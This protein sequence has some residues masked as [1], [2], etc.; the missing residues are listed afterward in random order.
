MKLKATI[1]SLLSVLLI[2]AVGIG[3]Y[4]AMPAIVGTIDGSRYYTAEELQQSYDK[5]YADGAKSETEL[6][7][8][9][10]YY[11]NLVDE[12][13]LNVNT[14][15]QEITTLT[16]SNEILKNLARDNEQTINNLQTVIN[17]NDDKIAS[18]NTEITALKK[19]IAY[20][21]QLVANLEIDG[22]A[23]VTFEFDGKVCNFQVIDKN[24]TVMV[25]D[26][27]STDY[28]IFNGWTVDGQPVDLTTYQ[29]TGNTRFVADVTYRYQISFVADNTKIDSYLITQGQP[30]A[31]P[32]LP[33]KDGYA[34]DGWSLDGVNPIDLAA[35][36][37][38][39]NTVLIAVFTKLH[40]V[41]FVQ[42]DVIIAT[43][44]VRHNDCVV[45]PEIETGNNKIFNGWKLSD[46]II[47]L[48]NYHV[49]N[50]L[51]L[52]AEI[53]SA[54]SY[55]EQVTIAG[56]DKINS[57]S[58]IWTD[59]QNTYY[60][61]FD[62]QL[63][64]NKATMTWEPKTWH[65][66]T[67]QSGYYVWTDGNNT[68]YTGSTS[69]SYVLNSQ[70]STW[71]QIKFGGSYF[72]VSAATNIWYDGD[73]IYYSQNQYHQVVFNKETL[74]WDDM[75]WNGDSDFWASSVWTDGE[76]CYRGLN[77]VLDRATN[78]W[79][80]KTWY[81][82]DGVASLN[83]WTDGNEVYG[84]RTVSGTDTHYILDKNTDTWHIKEWD[85]FAPHYTNSFWTD[86][87]SY[88]Y[89]TVGTDYKL[90]P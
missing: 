4:C 6:L 41:T 47:D 31:V 1:I 8:Q 19:S 68:Y 20:Y 57:P 61:S 32:T 82:L 27:V 78:T 49:T 26:P 85:G 62:T 45:A 90:I 23:V 81:G 43:E 16:K 88:Y 12:Y 13:Y 28:V 2:A 76:N 5:G 84:I 63:V 35:H 54:G 56:A 29:V 64:L 59:G 48:T 22:Q 75:K 55:F 80:E 25:N 60:S 39:E 46:E 72:T 17:A 7:G 18:L 66:Y 89:N 71:S 34:F 9:V 65:G 21:E 37:V 3:I 38:T 10:Q 87:E 69:V 15:N 42:S 58:S 86:G 36:V 83:I 77:Y 53:V 50:D 40:T 74:S 79:V 73:K 14:L 24:T 33:T 11:R 67:P 51:T 44:T 30:I 52:V 70:T